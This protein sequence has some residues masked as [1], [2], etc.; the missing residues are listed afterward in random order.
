MDYNELQ[1]SLPVCDGLNHLVVLV[2]REL[3]GGGGDLRES[4]LEVGLVLVVDLVC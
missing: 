2:L 4:L 3:V 1:V